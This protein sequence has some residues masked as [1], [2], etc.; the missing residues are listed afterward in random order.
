MESLLNYLEEKDEEV[1]QAEMMYSRIRFR[2]NPKEHQ[3]L[4]QH[5]TDT[6]ALLT[7]SKIF[8]KDHVSSLAESFTAESQRVLKN[9]WRRVKRGELSFILTKYASLV[10][11]LGALIAAGYFGKPYFSSLF[12]P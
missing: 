11:F 9:E 8:E 1:R 4:L 6:H 2:L 7:S 5:L 3:K 12:A 10:I